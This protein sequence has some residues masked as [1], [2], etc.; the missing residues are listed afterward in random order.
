MQECYESDDELWVF[1]MG[2]T[3]LTLLFSRF[4]LVHVLGAVFGV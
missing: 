1:R 2:S 4:F 3:F